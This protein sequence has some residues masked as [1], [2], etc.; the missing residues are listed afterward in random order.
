MTLLRT[1]ALVVVLASLT[2]PAM[3]KEGRASVVQKLADCRK[4][5]DNAARLTCYDQ[6]AAALDQA[7]AKGDVIVMDREQ[8]REVRKQAFGFTL[9]SISIFAKGEASEDVASFDSVLSTARRNG[10]GH[11]VFKLEDG[12]V[13]EQVGVEE[14]FKTP[15]PG[16]KVR[17]RKGALGSYMMVIESVGSFKAH[18][19][20]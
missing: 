12:A 2:A 18:R 15:K 20:E 19:L 9:P 10:A 3:A 1:T 6:T 17:I 13:W 11:W 4:I 5:T 7:E 14:M 16:M 8:A